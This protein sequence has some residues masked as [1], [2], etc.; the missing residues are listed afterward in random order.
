MN[1]P[2]S[3]VSC[4]AIGMILGAGR[5]SFAVDWPNWR[6]PNHDGLSPERDFRTSWTQPPKTVWEFPVGAGFSSFTCVAGK[7][8][9]CGTKDKQQTAFCLDAN[10]GT[11]IWATPFEKE[12]R[13]RQGGDG[14]RATPT[15]DG[16]RVYVIGALGLLLC[17]DAEKGT[18]IWRRQ[19]HNR[20]LWGYSA[21]VLIEG[22]WAIVSP[23]GFEGALLALDKKTGR[24]VWKCATDGPGYSTPYPF[25]FKGTRYIAGFVAGQLVI[26]VATSGKEVFRTSWKT[27]WNI[28]ATAPI[29]HDGQLFLS[30]GDNSGAAV[31]R[32]SAAGGERLSAAEVWRGKSLSCMFQSCVLKD[33]VLY[34]GDEKALKCVEFL[35][36]RLLWTVRDMAHATVL[37]ADGHLI[38]LTEEGKLMIAKATP[39]EFKPIAEAQVLTG[40]CW[41]LPTLC[42]GKLY[43]RNLEKAVCLD[44]SPQS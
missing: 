28:N 9:T 33:G 3:V 19:F 13:E 20:P 16:G 34:G 25:T 5:P 6:G 41:T 44:L 24:D 35:T 2:C 21:S 4:L 36:G 38:V 32:L 1:R 31:Y 23:G 7:L 10:T 27:P 30:S 14:P 15:V 37:W 26:A 43:L 29:H 11:L 22:D 12:Y 17:L 18:E 40:R 8:Y 39:A 42:N